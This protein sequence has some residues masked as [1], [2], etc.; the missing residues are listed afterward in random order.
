MKKVGKYGRRR[1]TMKRKIKE[2]KESAPKKRYLEERDE[3][4]AERKQGT[5]KKILTRGS[6]QRTKIIKKSKNKS[7]VGR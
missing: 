4:D 2:K 6:K 5:K 1:K 3:I 7:E